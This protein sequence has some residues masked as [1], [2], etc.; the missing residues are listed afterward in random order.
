M[1]LFH[2]ELRFKSPI[3]III[4]IIIIIPC[5]IDTLNWAFYFLSTKRILSRC[6]RKFLEHKLLLKCL[7]VRS[8]NIKKEMMS[9]MEKVV[10]TNLKVLTTHNH[11]STIFAYCKF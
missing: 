11:E 8:K 2:L 10:V 3:I 1:V 5:A 4:I 9:L 7:I 6:V